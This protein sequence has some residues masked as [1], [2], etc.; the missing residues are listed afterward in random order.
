MKQLP[1]NLY[2]RALD[3]AL[4]KWHQDFS[5]FPDDWVSEIAE[6][7]VR[8]FI[9]QASKLYLRD[10][11]SQ[12]KTTEDDYRLALVRLVMLPC[13]QRETAEKIV[14]HIFSQE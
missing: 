14:D 5:K 12:K 6:S 9:T 8:L 3:E 7:Q 1:Q 11:G 2:D 4:A 13:I 10:F